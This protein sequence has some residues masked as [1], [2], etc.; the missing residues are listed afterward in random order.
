MRPQLI[1]RML[2]A[3]IP[4]DN[5][6]AERAAKAAVINHFDR[7]ASEWPNAV[8]ISE[9]ELRS[10]GRRADLV[11]IDEEVV[12]VEIKTHGDSLS[13]LSGQIDTFLAAFPRV[14]VAVATRHLLKTRMLIP[15]EVGVI[16][17]RQVPG[18]V[19][20]VQHRK[21]KKSNKLQNDQQL[22][23]L[24]VSPIAKLIR[25][26][27]GSKS[28]KSRADCLE[29]ARGIPTQRVALAVRAHLLEKYQKSNQAFRKITQGRDISEG[30]IEHLRAW[31]TAKAESYA[32]DS[33]DDVFF[34]W[35]AGQST[36]N[37]FG[38]VPEDVIVKYK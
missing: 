10:S 24:P 15:K 38:P 3:P 22:S 35:L 26:Y 6:I 9:L 36:E 21:A 37:P 1:K 25:E 28:P 13:R 8:I 4:T 29:I 23:V 11:I 12:A 18:T 5:R 7:T 27:S 33:F 34:R 31:K 17:L 20:A 30:D 14:Y 2:A 32:Y 16:E 19:V